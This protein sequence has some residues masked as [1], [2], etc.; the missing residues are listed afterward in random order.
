M[1]EKG[2][3]DTI[4]CTCNSH[5][6]S[7]LVS[8]PLFT[9]NLCISARGCP[10]AH[11]LVQ[12]RRG[13]SPVT[14]ACVQLAANLALFYSDAR[15]ERK[16]AVTCAEPKHVLKP[17]GAPLGAVQ[18]RQESR[19]IVGYPDD[20]PDECHELR[21]ESGQSADF[22]RTS[23]KSQNRKKTQVALQQ[24]KDKAKQKKKQKKSQ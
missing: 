16:S 18:L 7:L 4:F 9:R 8:C 24:K 2:T 15:T 3:I 20:V 12:Q 6:I 13:S 1:E 21:S 10:G 23:N 14:D 22:Y 19:V 5:T 17:P 11:V